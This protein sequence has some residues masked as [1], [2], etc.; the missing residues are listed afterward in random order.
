MSEAKAKRQRVL[1][2]AKEKARAVLALWT[3]RRRPLDVCRELSIKPSVLSHWQE[4]AMEGMLGALE[5]RTPSSSEP[6]PMLPKKVE[7]LL[8][9]KSARAPLT[10]LS[11]RLAKLQQ[12]RASE[13]LVPRFAG[14]EPAASAKA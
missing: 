12:T 14:E 4:R 2:S 8:A 5:P 10:R 11:R 13:K 7:R 3:E 1:R 6:K 9:R